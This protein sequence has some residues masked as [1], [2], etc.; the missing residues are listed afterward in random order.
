MVLENST[1]LEVVLGKKLQGEL[2]R[3][4]FTLFTSKPGEGIESGGVLYGELSEDRVAV[5][6]YKEV[7]EEVLDDL[8]TTG[9]QPFAGFFRIHTRREAGLSDAEIEVFRDLRGLL[10]L[11]IKPISV[12]RAEAV[13]HVREAG[14]IEERRVTLR[15]D[16]EARPR[17]PRPPSPSPDSRVR[18]S[19]RPLLGALAVALTLALGAG[20][21]IFEPKAPLDLDFQVAARGPE[22][23]ATWKLLGRPSSALHDAALTVRESGQER[24]IDLTGGFLGAGT[25]KVRPRSADIV[26]TMRVRYQGVAPVE[27]TVTYVGLRPAG[28][29]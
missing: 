22:L 6:A 18:I 9:P 21:V 23:V 10:F 1:G 25:A 17:R 27:K 4:A 11:T 2:C 12:S 7:G 29:P 3:R 24:T 13:L 19:T 28:R 15:A 14:R 8:L 20:W 5:E 16:D 26:L